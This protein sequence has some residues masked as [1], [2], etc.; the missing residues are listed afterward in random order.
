MPIVI[1]NKKRLVIFISIAALVIAAIVWGII[2]WTGGGGGGPDDAQNQEGV[3][4]AL[5]MTVDEAPNDKNSPSAL[6]PGDVMVI[7]PE[8]HSWSE[9][10]R[11]SYLLLKL[12][13]KKSDADKLVQAKTKKVQVRDAEPTG[14]N[15]QPMGPEEE[16]VLARQYRLKIEKLDFKASEI[17]KGQ[18]YPDKI[19]DDGMIEKK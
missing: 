15:G 17:W 3:Y 5:I 10:E 8:G 12:K 16:T 18:P 14:E 1:E 7:F 13:L 11:V 6:R 19:F 2:K 9:T 4:E